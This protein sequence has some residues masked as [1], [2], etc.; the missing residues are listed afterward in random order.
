MDVEQKIDK[1]QE[2]AEELKNKS[3]LHYL[4][5][6]HS[7]AGLS[8]EESLLSYLKPNDIG[9]LDIAIS[10]T[11]LRKEFHNHLHAY[12]NK[13]KINSVDELKF[14]VKRRLS[15]EKLTAPRISIG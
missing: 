3:V 2:S 15:L 11:S 13:N 5:L 1:E 12:Y 9:K 6:Q 14:I 4:A 10:E 7:Q 8:F